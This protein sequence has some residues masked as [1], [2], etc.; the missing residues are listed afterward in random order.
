MESLTDI[1]VFVL[2]KAVP[3]KTKEVHG[4]FERLDIDTERAMAGNDHAEIARV[5]RVKLDVTVAQRGFATI[6][7][8]D[9]ETGGRCPGEMRQENASH[10]TPHDKAA[11]MALKSESLRTQAFCVCQQP[12]PLSE[13]LV[14]AAQ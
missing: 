12:F 7:L 14:I 11:P 5:A 1:Q 4:P 13:Y 3:G 6:R 8:V 2:G 10:C 9:A